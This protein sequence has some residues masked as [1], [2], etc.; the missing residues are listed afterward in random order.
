VSEHSC[1]GRE[2]DNGEDVWAVSRHTDWAGS[3]RTERTVELTLR[4]GPPRPL[5]ATLSEAELAS[6]AKVLPAV[7]DAVRRGEFSRIQLGAAFTGAIGRDPFRQVTMAGGD[8]GLFAWWVD[9]VYVVVGLGFATDHGNRW[10]RIAGWAFA[11]VAVADLVT[12]GWRAY[13]N[14]SVARTDRR[15]R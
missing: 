3:R 7:A 15:L 4:T 5:V 11:T 2:D 10:L 1:R 9:L 8:R 14:R 6:V 13:R 12:S